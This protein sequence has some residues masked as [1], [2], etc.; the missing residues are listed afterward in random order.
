MAKFTILQSNLFNCLI[1]IN[2]DRAVTF[3][4]EKFEIHV[5][6]PNEV[7][8]NTQIIICSKISIVPFI[9][10]ASTAPNKAV[11]LTIFKD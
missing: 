1:I 3:L 10:S 2:A 11:A 7:K 9:C 8:R 4:K 6:H 5:A